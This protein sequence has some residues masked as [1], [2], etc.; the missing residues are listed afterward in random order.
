[1]TSQRIA[2]ATPARWVYTEYTEDPSQS[3][4][5]SVHHQTSQQSVADFCS[6]QES[7]WSLV[8][9]T[10]TH[11]MPGWLLAL[12]NFFEDASGGELLR[13]LCEL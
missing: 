6:I 8:P 3:A 7:A 1:M 5:L 10:I 4:F 2:R 12:P 11:L 9:S 13:E